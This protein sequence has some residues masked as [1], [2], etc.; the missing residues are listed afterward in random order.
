MG[1]V[2]VAEGIPACERSGFGFGNAWC[3]LSAMFREPRNAE[4]S[5]ASAPYRRPTGGAAQSRH[6]SLPECALHPGPRLP[7]TSTCVGDRAGLAGQHG[8]HRHRLFEHRPGGALRLR[9]R[10]RPTIAHPGGARRTDAP[11]LATV[12]PTLSPKNDSTASRHRRKRKRGHVPRGI[13]VQHSTLGL[14]H[15]L[16]TST[17]IGQPF[18]FALSR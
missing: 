17:A 18:L 5:E 10:R 1:V 14:D 8:I 3:Y 9:N 12:S 6:I 7:A 4:S 15:N 2:H 11:N 13:S 16:S